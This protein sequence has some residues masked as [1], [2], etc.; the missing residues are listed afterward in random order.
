MKICLVS[1]YD[2]SKTGGVTNHIVNYAI[3]LRDM[4]ETVTILTTSSDERF[5]LEGIKIFNLGRPVPIHFGSTVAQILLNWKSFFKI[6]KFFAKNKFDIVHI[7]EP[8]VPFLATFSIIFSKS[9][10]VVTFHATL[11]KSWM[12]KAWGYL[13]K[14]WLE[15]KETFIAVSESA[16]NSLSRYNY[17]FPVQIL[18]NGVSKNFFNESNKN[19]NK[20]KIKILFVGRNE[21]RKGVEVLIESFK[22]LK[23]KNIKKNFELIMIGEN[24]EKLKYIYDYL[25]D[26]K[27][28]A[29]IEGNDLI[30]HYND[31]HILCSPA[32]ENESFGIVLIEAMASKVAVLAS[33]INGY[34]DLIDNKNGLL[35]KNKDINDLSNKLTLLIENDNLRNNLIN[36]GYKFSTKYNWQ[37][38]SKDILK[39][40]KY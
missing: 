1:P 3:E 10:T 26:C 11:N 8:L 40:Y 7:H 24:I 37:N 17:N 28:L 38:I 32:I 20:N 35:F 13:F 16:K 2:I 4:G 14:P 9:K 34:N 5:Y 19:K 27:F 39:I 18:P 31:S 22:I 23:S 6:K 15:D 29:H 30:N 12:F 25:D 36:N 21:E 33:D